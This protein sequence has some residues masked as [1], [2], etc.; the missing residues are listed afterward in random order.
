[1]HGSV[2]PVH[3]PAPRPDGLLQPLF[4][5]SIVPVSVLRIFL[6]CHLPDKGFV[7][8]AQ[9]SKLFSVEAMLNYSICTFVVTRFHTT[10]ALCQDSKRIGRNNLVKTKVHII[11]ISIDSSENS[12]THC[13]WLRVGC[14]F[15]MRYRLSGLIVFL[16]CAAARFPSCALL[17]CTANNLTLILMN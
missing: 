10:T 5:A 1:M 2:S 15:L 12:S 16:G 4:L 17:Y 9:W 14:C 13:V 3:Q 7:V 11:R 6:V 8:L